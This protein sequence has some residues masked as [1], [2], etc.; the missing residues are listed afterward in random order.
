MKTEILKALEE[1]R[2]EEKRKFEQSVDLIV[3]LK[4]FD[5]RRD[6]VNLSINLPH[7]IKDYK[8]AA[9][10]EQKSTAIPTI[11]RSEMKAMKDKKKIK[12]VIKDYDY[13][14]ASAPLMPEVAKTF[15]KYLGPTGKMPAP[16]KGIIGSDDEASINREVK[17]FDG[18]VKIKT[19]EASIKIIVG[20]ES[21]KDED[22]EENIEFIYKNLLNSL[23]RNKDNIK[24]VMIKL[25]MSKPKKIKL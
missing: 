17:K 22:I 11:T 18:L 23:S 6:S 3:N 25:T 4:G 8:I 24:N 21:M 15:G 7:K 20:K 14:I 2:K 12:Q 13:F 9:F 19:K 1:L 5:T 16:G 10:L